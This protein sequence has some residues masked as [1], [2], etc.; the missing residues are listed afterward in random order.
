MSD[1]RLRLRPETLADGFNNTVFT[2]PI[3]FV[4]SNNRYYITV[5][6][7]LTAM[8]FSFTA[9]CRDGYAFA[10]SSEFSCRNTYGSYITQIGMLNGVLSENDTLQTFSV[11]Y[12]STAAQSKPAQIYFTNFDVVQNAPTLQQQFLTYYKCNDD[13]LNQLSKK[14]FQVIDRN[15]QSVDIDLTNYIASLRLYPFE[16]GASDPLDIILGNYNIQVKSPLAQAIYHEIDLGSVT[17]APTNNNSND[18]NATIKII[19]PF[20]GMQ[21]LTA[22]WYA[23]QTI[24]LKYNVDITSGLCSATLYIDN[25]PI[26]I[27]T[28]KIGKDMPYKVSNQY[29][30]TNLIDTTIQDT[31]SLTA[32][33][34][35]LYHANYNET[36]IVNDYSNVLMSDL[37][38]KD[39]GYCEIDNLALPY[40]MT[41]EIQDEIRQVLR[42]GI[43]L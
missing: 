23:G 41:K 37:T 29:V 13:I 22:T 26:D 4:S 31:Y 35:V 10:R 24:N 30:N 32:I 11:Q 25:V 1:L 36:S 28:G 21:S 7:D 2:P 40:D 9:K 16:I 43:I 3:E 14:A 38:E 15:G 19:L 20:I 18:Y 17:L 34:T 8:T 33:I 6:E 27:F 5:N 39:I 12:Q 42:N